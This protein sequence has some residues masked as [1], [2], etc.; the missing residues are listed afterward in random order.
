[1][2]GHGHT[3]A[4]RAIRQSLLS[5]HVKAD[6]ICLLSSISPVLDHTIRLVYHRMIRWF[7]KMWGSIYSQ[8]KRFSASLQREMF[9]WSHQKLKTILDREAPQ[10]VICTHAFALQTLGE[11]KRRGEINVLLYAVPTD[12][13]VNS[14]W[15]HDEVNGYFVGNRQLKQRLMQQWGVS[16]GRITVSGIPVDPRFSA[17]VSTDRGEQRK[18]LG[19]N[20]DRFTLLI[21][22][23]GMGI[24]PIQDV[25][26]A[27]RN[28]RTTVQTTVI[29]GKNEK[30]YQ[31]LKKTQAEAGSLRLLGYVSN[32]H[33]WMRASDCMISKPGGLTCAEALALQIPLCMYK[34][35]PGQEWANTDWLH[36]QRLAYF[37]KT[38][39]EG[40]RFIEDLATNPERMSRWKNMMKEAARP[41]ASR[42]IA[43]HVLQDIRAE[44]REVTFSSSWLR[45]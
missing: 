27:V 42:D 22:G 34:P 2:A 26:K 11:L 12:Y 35:I 7:P 20:P 6:I 28:I 30:L 3:R 41:D 25:L 37:C 44:G 32:M 1:M 8:E 4:A 5:Y 43:R 29:V 17:T 38:T 23:G 10:A 18:R 21:T 45:D 36:Q 24:G 16:E 33:E 14:F 13:H 15:V 19:L 31:K 40:V 9:R 39:D